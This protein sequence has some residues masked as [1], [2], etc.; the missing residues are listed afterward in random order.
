MREET[1]HIREQQTRLRQEMRRL[2][3][4]QRHRFRTLST[5]ADDTVSI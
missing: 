2:G 5:T 1:R 4:Q 3:E